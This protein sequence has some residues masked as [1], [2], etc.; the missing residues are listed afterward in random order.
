[1]MGVHGALQVL[2]IATLVVF[3]N[4]LSVFSTRSKMTSTAP[5]QTL[6]KPHLRV[7]DVS[8][9]QALGAFSFRYGGKFSGDLLGD[10][11]REEL[12]KGFVTV[13]SAKR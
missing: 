3:L 5:D 1:M 12:Y 6:P 4:G 2:A 11:K 9:I 13:S 8:P 7:Q 10:W